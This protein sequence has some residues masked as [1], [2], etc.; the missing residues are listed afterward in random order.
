MQD[1]GVLEMEVV[2]I[3]EMPMSG[4]L[5]WLCSKENGGSPVF[6]TCEIQGAQQMSFLKRLRF[7]R[8]PRTKL[9]LGTRGCYSTAL[10]T[11]KSKDC[12]FCSRHLKVPSETIHCTSKLLIKSIVG[13]FGA[14]FQT[15]EQK[16]LK[17][18]HFHQLGD[19]MINMKDQEIQS[20]FEHLIFYI[21]SMII[22]NQDSFGTL[23]RCIS[24][25]NLLLPFVGLKKAYT[26][27]YRS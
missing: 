7:L 8:N 5:P 25:K 21:P 12:L 13:K 6:G 4:D 20:H 10:S 18:K 19:V 3:P 14:N 27:I 15:I 26:C 23:V 11:V 9:M 17:K 16:N 24:F 2:L 1:V 22:S